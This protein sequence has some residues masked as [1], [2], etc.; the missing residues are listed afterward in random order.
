MKCID[1]PSCSFPIHAILVKIGLQLNA[2]LGTS[3]IFIACNWANWDCKN[4]S[5]KRGRAK[6]GSSMAINTGCLNITV[7]D[8]LTERERV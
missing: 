3:R 8:K 1:E 2:L 6:L 4:V 7:L 5:Y